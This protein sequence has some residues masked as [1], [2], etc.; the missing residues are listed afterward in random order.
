MASSP[1]AQLAAWGLEELL[2]AHPGLAI[3]PRAGGELLIAG[4]FRFLAR[5]NGT[6]IEDSYRIEMT[7]SS[8]FP[9][10][11]PRVKETGGRIPLDFH[12]YPDGTLC[13]GSPIRLCLILDVG[14]TLAEFTE[15][16]L[17]AYLFAYS[18]KEKYGTLPFGELGEVVR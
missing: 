17:L 11:L 5:S 10:E 3:R 14:A 13:L 18:Y 12:H 6:E 8:D 9:R 16:C 1:R 7:V 2:V 15:R 4:E